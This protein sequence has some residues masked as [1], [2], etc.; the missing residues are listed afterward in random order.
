MAPT[1]LGTDTL[2]HAFALLDPA[3]QDPAAALPD[4]V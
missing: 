1:A 4:S 3:L 2:L